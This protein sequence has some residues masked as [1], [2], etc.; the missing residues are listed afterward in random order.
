MANRQRTKEEVS[1]FING[2]V[3]QYGGKVIGNGGPRVK[4]TFSRQLP[5]DVIAEMHPYY[6]TIMDRPSGVEIWFNVPLIKKSI[7]TYFDKH[8][9]R[10]VA[11]TVVHELCHACHFIKNPNDY[12]KRMH[13]GY[14]YKQCFQKAGKKFK[15][16]SKPVNNDIVVYVDE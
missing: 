3:R 2:V 1:R 15:K 6:D 5:K 7:G 10:A 9:K 16:Y 11:G 4:V 14:Q 13:S 8:E 12:E